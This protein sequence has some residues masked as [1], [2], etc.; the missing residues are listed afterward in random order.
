MSPS[1]SLCIPT[2]NQIDCFRKTLDSIAIQDFANY[3]IIITDDSPDDSVRQLLHAYS[4]KGEVRYFKN[5]VRKGSPENWN[6]AVRYASGDY[7]KMLHH[8]DWF[9]RSDSLSRYVALLENAPEAD[10]AFSATQI[11][12]P[13]DDITRLHFPSAEQLERLRSEP[14]A[15]FMGNFVGGPSATL[16]LFMG[17]LL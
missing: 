14:T 15:L 7:I 4:F 8:D 6:E 16:Y 3:E 13:D 9:T 12:N 10:F 17:L 1:V 11:V 5:D 2:Y